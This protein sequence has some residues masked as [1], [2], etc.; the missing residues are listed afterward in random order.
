MGEKEILKFTKDCFESVS[1][2][3]YPNNFLVSSWWMNISKRNREAICNFDNP[4]EAIHYAQTGALTGFDHRDKGLK[5]VID[6]KV[7]EL[8]RVFPGFIF[9]EHRGLKESIYSRPETLEEVNGILYSNI[10][11][12]HL[13]FYLR[14][15][16]TF[17]RK[18]SPDRVLEIGGGYGALARIFKIMNPSVH[19]T[20]TDLPESLFFFTIVFAIKLS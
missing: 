15:T 20:I 17:V 9:K 10:F 16:L 8:E 4:S 5:S 7:N 18:W 3:E 19:Y 14:T 2:L 13:N 11:L 12:T 1:E 6:Y